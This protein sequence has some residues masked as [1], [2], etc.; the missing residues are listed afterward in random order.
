MTPLIW[1][2]ASERTRKRNPVTRLLLDSNANVNIETKDSYRVIH[3]AALDGN[4]ECLDQLLKYR[5]DPEARISIIG[6][7]SL[8]VI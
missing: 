6:L 5:A 7:K 2:S 4:L 1:A 3:L 8:D